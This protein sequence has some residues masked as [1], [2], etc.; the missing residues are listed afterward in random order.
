MVNK[1]HGACTFTGRKKRIINFIIFHKTNTAH[2]KLAL[3]SLT[4]TFNSVDVL[5]TLDFDIV[6]QKSTFK[7]ILCLSFCRFKLSMIGRLVLLRLQNIGIHSVLSEDHISV[8]DSICMFDRR[9]SFL[10]VLIALC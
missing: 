2:R 6:L 9:L 5:F 10:F 3:A 4:C 7:L 1:S 8:K